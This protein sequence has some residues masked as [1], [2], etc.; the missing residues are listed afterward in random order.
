MI[1]ESHQNSM[2]P[3]TPSRPAPIPCKP[4]LCKQDAINQVQQQVPIKLEYNK[5]NKNDKK[6]YVFI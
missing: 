4:Q 6:I 2:K 5:L 3:L 1:K